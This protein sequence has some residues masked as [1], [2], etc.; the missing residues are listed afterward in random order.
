MVCHLWLALATINLSTKFEASTSTHYEYMNVE[1]G[2][3]GVLVE[4]HRPEPTLP[5]FG[6]PIGGDPVE[7]AKILGKK[8]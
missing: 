5:L 4:N 7:F 8:N 1:N 6:P 2:A 3:F